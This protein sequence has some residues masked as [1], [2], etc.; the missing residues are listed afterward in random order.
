M[1]AARSSGFSR[2]ATGRH[3]LPWKPPEGGTPNETSLIAIF[4]RDRKISL[5][6]FASLRMTM[7]GRMLEPGIEVQR[8]ICL[9]NNFL[10]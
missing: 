6:S 1:K 8:C 2:S 9:S 4:A 5:R 10:R 3:N 7:A